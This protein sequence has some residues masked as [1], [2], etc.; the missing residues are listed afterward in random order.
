MYIPGYAPHNETATSD[1]FEL[2]E[3]SVP[4]EMGTEVCDPPPALIEPASVAL[5]AVRKSAMRIGDVVC[6]VGCG[7][8]G[9]LTVQCAAIGGAGLVI[10]IEPDAERRELALATGSSLD[11]AEICRAF[12]E[13]LL[14]RKPLSYGAVWIRS[15]LVPR[16][17][18]YTIYAATA[19]GGV[20]REPRLFDLRLQRVEVDGGVEHVEPLAERRV[21]PRHHHRW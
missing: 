20:G 15:E 5:H 9:L 3:F 12:L 21:G 8:I 14:A 17:S 7:P 16:G 10:A 1:S 19:T 11:P 2:L 13:T 6:V 18:T 4:A